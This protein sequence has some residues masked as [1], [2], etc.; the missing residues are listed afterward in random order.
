VDEIDKYVLEQAKIEVE[1]TRSWPTKILA[2]YVAINAGVV[3][4][5]FSLANRSTD[6]LRASMCVKAL[7]TTAIVTLSIWALV[8]LAKNH[9]SYL[10]HRAVQVQFQLANT[11]AITAKYAVPFEWLSPVEATLGTRALGWGFYAYLVLLVA[12]L[13]VVGVWVS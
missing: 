5:L 12:V 11:E 9:R 4:A 1:H 10:R 6:P 2:F 7:L 13:G 8:L 3:T